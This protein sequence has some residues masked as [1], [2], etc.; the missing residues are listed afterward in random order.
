MPVKLIPNSELAFMCCDRLIR[1]FG[2]FSLSSFRQ[3]CFFRLSVLF[4][5]VV[6]SLC[7]FNWSTL[8]LKAEQ[9]L[10][11]LCTF[12]AIY[13]NEK[14][15]YFCQKILLSAA[16][17]AAALSRPMSCER[18]GNERTAE[19]EG[20]T[21]GKRIQMPRTNICRIISV[22]QFDEIK[23]LGRNKKLK[24]PSPSYRLI[25]T[26][27]GDY[28]DDASST[29]R[30]GTDWTCSGRRIDARCARIPYFYL[31][32]GVTSSS[33]SI[34]LIIFFSRKKIK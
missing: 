11:A 10:N 7:S 2:S 29:N 26:V 5:P 18:Q 30:Q 25:D 6:R 32:N 12:T 19:R 27:L 21:S 24:D 22:I 28:L 17:A 13:A 20:N 8:L 33:I 31:I 1:R 23:S 16:A 14:F 4:V 9:Q 34:L 3:R 15:L